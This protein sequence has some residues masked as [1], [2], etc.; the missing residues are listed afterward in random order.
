[1]GGW[2]PWRR[3]LARM[4]CAL[5]LSCGTRARSRSAAV[6]GV[7]SPANDPTA[8]CADLTDLRVCWDD[9]KKQ[10][11][12]GICVDRRPVPSE[13]AASPLGW[14]CIGAGNGRLCVDRQRTAGLFARRG[15]VWT[16][17]YPRFPDDGEWRCGEMAGAVVCAG[18]DPPA[19]VAINVADPA[20]ICG[21]R[22]A[23]EANPSSAERICVDLAPDFP[24]GRA[25]GWRCRYASGPSTV[26]TCER[27]AASHQLGDACDPRNPCL[28]GL[29]C[30]ASRCVPAK[31]SPSCEIDRDC[32]SGACRLGTCLA[33]EP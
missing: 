23:R 27:D 12:G 2:A 6:D 31:P 5:V 30:A 24:D 33:A 22:R 26:R 32:E 18:G 28:D 20:W 1:M 3:W 14:R 9:E 25:A 4:G 7:L 19:G 21:S 29:R 15:D 10:C 8:H 11:P 13:P 16:Q 17:R